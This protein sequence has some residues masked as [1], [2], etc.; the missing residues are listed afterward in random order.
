MFIMSNILFSLLLSYEQNYCI[1]ITCIKGYNNRKEGK[2]T[3]TG[4]D[5]LK[6]E[7]IKNE[8]G[9]DSPE[10]AKEIYEKFYKNKS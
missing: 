7:P 4:S 3:N 10:T 2:M 6:N 9:V 8:K 1:V 5:Y